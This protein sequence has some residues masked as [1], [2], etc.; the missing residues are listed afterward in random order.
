MKVKL[1][2]GEKLSSMNNYCGLDYDNWVA[3]NQ[4]K[5]V[6]LGVVPEDIKDKVEEVKIASSKQGGK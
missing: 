6:E 2:E 5:S 1:I 3:L 4:G